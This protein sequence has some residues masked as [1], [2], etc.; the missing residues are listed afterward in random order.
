M[1]CISPV[2]IRKNGRRDVVPCG[3]CNFC[4]QT[5]RFDWSFRIS[6]ELKV[7]TSAHFLTLTYS[8][9][10]PSFDNQVHKEHLQLFFKRLRKLSVTRLRYYAVGEY[11]TKTNRAHYHAIIFNMDSNA[12]GA[13]PSIWNS[14]FVH[15]GTV[16]PASI[17]YVTKYVINRDQDFKG[18]E[19]PFALMSRRPG[20]GS[21][22]LVTHKWWHRDD[23]RFY[24]QVNGV[25]AR[26]PRFYKDKFFTQLERK[27]MVP[28]MLQDA[29]ERFALELERLALVHPDPDNYFDERERSDHDRVRN[30]IN[31]LNK[32]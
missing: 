25:K 15:V 7:S 1:R 6:Q 10:N 23:M 18:R 32:F 11:G 4:L 24:S 12:V 3:K 9:E 21:N 14:G 26:L 30:K 19:P 8:D 5:K 2:L 29:D 31:S 20:L 28:Q 16:T 22:Y 13:L 27:I 17:H